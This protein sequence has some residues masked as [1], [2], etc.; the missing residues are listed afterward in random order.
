[1]ENR[2]RNDREISYQDAQW[3][4]L[5]YRFEAGTPSV[6]DAIGF[7]RAI[8][9]FE[10]L[11]KQDVLQ[12]EQALLNSATAQLQDIE[13]LSLVGTAPNKVSVVSFVMSGGHPA[14]I[15]FLLDRQGIAIRTGHHCAEPLMGRLGLP[16]T[17]RASFAV[18][19]S[20][21]EVDALARGLKKVQMML[22]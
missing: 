17:A 16:G 18:Y 10:Q 9:W 8:E 15:G 11:S 21:D 4:V 20:L 1:M 22:E 5:P 14:D 19:N 2:W 3:N 13:S 6:A 12:H 7:G